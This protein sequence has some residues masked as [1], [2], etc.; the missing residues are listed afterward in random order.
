MFGLLNTVSVYPS[1]LI[2]SSSSTRHSLFLF[3][4]RASL[5]TM[6][7]RYQLSVSV[8]VHEDAWLWVS[9]YFNL[10]RF[11][12]QTYVII[13]FFIFDY[14]KHHNV[15]FNSM[16]LFPHLHLADARYLCPFQHLIF[17]FQSEI[18]TVCNDS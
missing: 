18:H 11:F 9:A 7:S 2:L 12:N 16:I 10:L 6:S 4:V 17:L 13:K 5:L 15:C 8:V 3:T 14:Y 1:F